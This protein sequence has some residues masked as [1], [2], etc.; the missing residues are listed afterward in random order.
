MSRWQATETF[1]LEILAR[2]AKLDVNN[3]ILDIMG[4]KIFMDD[5]TASRTVSTYLNHEKENLKKA[6]TEKYRREYSLVDTVSSIGLESIVVGLRMSEVLERLSTN[7]KN[8][9][10]DSETHLVL[11]KEE[12]GTYM[13]IVLYDPVLFF[14]TPNFPFR[15]DVS[16]ELRRRGEEAVEWLVNKVKEKEPYILRL[17]EI[18]RETGSRSF[19][20]VQNGHNKRDIVRLLGV[21]GLADLTVIFVE[22]LA[23]RV[24]TEI[25]ISEAQYVEALLERVRRDRALKRVGFDVVT[26]PRPDLF[27]VVSGKEFVSLGDKLGAFETVAARVARA[28]KEV[29]EKAEQKKLR[30]RVSS[31]V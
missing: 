12:N 26:G 27:S 11:R 18:A 6:L 29:A 1:F 28:A 23:Q 7:V 15:F 20:W 8:L 2:H 4:M 5:L 17:F 19:K 25:K 13:Y 30:E 21:G 31:T 9:L 10:K 14:E 3:L 24:E 22:G 16:G